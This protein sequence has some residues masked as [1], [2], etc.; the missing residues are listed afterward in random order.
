MPGNRFEALKGDRKGQYPCVRCPAFD[1]FPCLVNGKADAQSV[2]IMANALRVG[3][4][5]IEKLG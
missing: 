2:C 3:D 4:P 5:L 1:G